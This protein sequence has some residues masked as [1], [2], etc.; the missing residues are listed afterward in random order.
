MFIDQER[1]IMDENQRVWGYT[2]LIGMVQAFGAGYFLWDLMVSAQYL[3]IFGPGFLTHAVCALCVFSLG[4]RPF[5]NYYAPNF[6]LY[7]LSSPFLNFHWFMDKL[8]MTGSLLQLIN[9]ICLL[10]VFFSCRLI[11]GTYSSFHVNYDIYQAW[12]APPSDIVAQGRD[13]PVWLALSYVTSNLILHFL[14]FYWFGKM[15]DAL[16]RRFDSTTKTKEPLPDQRGETSVE[17]EV[18]VEGADLKIPAA[19]ILH[20][21]NIRQRK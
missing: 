7:E 3:N 18:I 16:R 21:S 2:G 10:V 17:D 1:L 6:L 11:Y 15:I 9:G 14:N 19:S 13:V 8:E 4:F 12:K 20:Q 5:V